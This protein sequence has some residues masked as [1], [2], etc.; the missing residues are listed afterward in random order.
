MPS[1]LKSKLWVLALLWS[2]S[3]GY[4]QQWKPAMEGIYHNQPGALFTDF[5]I[6]FEND[7]P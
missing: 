4:A 6:N 1:L 5:V 7:G 3:I 2:S